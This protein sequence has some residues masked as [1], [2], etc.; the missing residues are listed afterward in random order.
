MV[1]VFT[2]EQQMVQTSIRVKLADTLLVKRKTGIIMDQQL[3]VEATM[4]QGTAVL[5]VNPFIY[6]SIPYWG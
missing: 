6:C 1:A 4:Y 2:T 3:K 5:A